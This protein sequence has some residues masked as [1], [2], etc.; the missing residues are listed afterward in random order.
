MP[1]VIADRFT[2]EIDHP[3]V[4]FLIGMRVNEFWAFNKWRWVA[5]QMPP[6]IEQLYTYG[7]K[8]GFLGSESFFRLFPL[9]TMMMTY[10]RSFEDLERFARSKD[11]P[12]LGAWQEFYRRVGTD[13]SVGIW[14]ET[15]Q[16]EPGRYEAVYANMPLFGLAKA[17]GKA[18]PV[19]GSHR[20]KARGRLTGR[21]AQLAPEL[22]VIH[23]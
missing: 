7:E 15:Y 3:F 6:M 11:D 13:G 4:V 12:H 21:E 9:T 5:S 10:W 14:H 23:E 1:P 20:S 18:I 16:I 22:D 17:T 8:K 2:A 19:R